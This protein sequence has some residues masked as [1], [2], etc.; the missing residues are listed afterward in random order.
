MSTRNIELWDIIL[1]NFSQYEARDCG[2]SKAMKW[3]VVLTVAYKFELPSFSN[4]EQLD[5]HELTK[6]FD[7]VQ[8]KVKIHQKV[9]VANKD[10][11]PLY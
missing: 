2:V 4:L 11:Q 7:K 1:Q 10:Q 8:G 5:D 9:I 3:I 6:K